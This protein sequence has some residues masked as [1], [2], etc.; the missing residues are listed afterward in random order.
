MQDRSWGFVLIAPPPK[1]TWY[2]GTL[3]VSQRSAGP[4]HPVP[5][6]SPHMAVISVIWHM[7]CT[8]VTQLCHPRGWFGSILDPSLCGMSRGVCRGGGGLKKFFPAEGR[9]GGQ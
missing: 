4:S 8:T 9:G 1:N 3:L 5:H 6:L 2:T 7:K